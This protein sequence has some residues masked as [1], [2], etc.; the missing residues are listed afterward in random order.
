MSGPGNFRRPTVYR[1]IDAG[2]AAWNVDVVQALRQLQD[3]PILKGRQIADVELT[4]ATTKVPHGLGRIPAG[5]FVVNA[6][7]SDTVWH[8][9]APTKDALY[10]LCT[11]TTTVDLWVF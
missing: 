4:T 2:Q 10:L 6:T 11:G 9:Q 5:F 3:L 7:S 8:A 1:P